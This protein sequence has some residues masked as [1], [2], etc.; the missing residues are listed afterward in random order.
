[1]KAFD[2]IKEYLPKALDYNIVKLKGKK[3]IFRLRI[4]KYRA[5]F[6]YDIKNKIIKIIDMDSR[7]DIY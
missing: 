5:I 3:Q 4:G 1:M 6:T 2:E 7:G